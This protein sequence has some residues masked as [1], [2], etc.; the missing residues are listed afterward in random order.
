M[1]FEWRSWKWNWPKAGTILIEQKQKWSP[2]GLHEFLAAP[3]PL[4]SCNSG[5][6]PQS[7]GARA[8]VQVQSYLVIFNLK[9]IRTEQSMNSKTRQNALKC[10]IAIAE[11]GNGAPTLLHT[12]DG[13]V[14]RAKHEVDVQN[15]VVHSQRA[16]LALGHVQTAVEV[17]GVGLA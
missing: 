16:A 13:Q 12:V 14:G 7:A 10:P 6:R 17:V 2:V 4:P 1:S 5:G 15:R 8:N 9:C 11:D 3:D